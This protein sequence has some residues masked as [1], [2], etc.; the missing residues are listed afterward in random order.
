MHARSSHLSP[1]A[2]WEALVRSRRPLGDVARIDH[3]EPPATVRSR[4]DV[5]P[6]TLREG[7]F[8]EVECH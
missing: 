5:S 4:E 1:L 3:D 8:Y 6:F 2:L 7:L